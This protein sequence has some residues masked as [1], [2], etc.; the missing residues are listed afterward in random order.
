MSTEASANFPNP[1]FVEPFRA[2]YPGLALL[3]EEKQMDYELFFSMRKT[4][5]L[6][7]VST[8]TL[9]RRVQQEEIKI[10]GIGRGRLHAED[11]EF[12]IREGR[13]R[14]GKSNVDRAGRTRGDI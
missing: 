14:K 6:F 13:P 11:L 4:G 10:R 2:R 3:I 5:K 1:D 7:G 9:Q 8:R 12:L